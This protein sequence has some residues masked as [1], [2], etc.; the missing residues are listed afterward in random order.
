MLGSKE[1]A[2][3]IVLPDTFGFGN[4]PLDCPHWA[5]E[6]RGEKLSFMAKNQNGE[7]L[8]EFWTIYRKCIC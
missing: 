7:F 1:R 6:G 5:I 2:W 3:S 4:G 8:F